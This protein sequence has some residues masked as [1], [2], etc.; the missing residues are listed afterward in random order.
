MN[1][2]YYVF[3]HT[4]RSAQELALHFVLL[5]FIIIII[6]AGQ[7]SR[8]VTSCPSVYSCT[9]VDTS[10]IFGHIKEYYSQPAATSDP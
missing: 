10:S 9:T 1:W 8:K 7:S 3:E 5:T 2:E 4:P 6:T